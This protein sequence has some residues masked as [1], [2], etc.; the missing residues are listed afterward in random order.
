MKDYILD[1]QAT[2]GRWINQTWSRL[3]Q[4]ARR[5]DK[6]TLTLHKKKVGRSKKCG[7]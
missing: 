2:C 3:V 7:L 4:L 5:A 6:H 1:M